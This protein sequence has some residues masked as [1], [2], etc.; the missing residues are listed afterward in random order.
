MMQ[1]QLTE[2]MHHAELTRADGKTITLGKRLQS[3]LDLHV[4]IARINYSKEVSI[5][6]VQQFSK[7]SFR[8]SNHADSGR[9]VNKYDSSVL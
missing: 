2:I 6:G 8:A 4:I 9:I 5:F 3:L 7:H 1:S